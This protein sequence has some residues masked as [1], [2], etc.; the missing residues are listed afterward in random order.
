MMG[1]ETAKSSTPQW[2]RTKLTDAFKVVM[3]GTEEDYGSL[4]RM[5]EKEFRNLHS[6]RVAFL[7]VVKSITIYLSYKYLF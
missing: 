3:G 6:R 7:E 1:I 5:H 2:V 4:W